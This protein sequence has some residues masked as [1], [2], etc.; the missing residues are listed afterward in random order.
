M[1]TARRT[2]RSW[3]LPPV[4]AAL[5]GLYRLGYKEPAWRLSP[6]R[7]ASVLRLQA[8]RGR[9]RGQR[10]FVI[11]NGPSLK[12]TDLARL[13]GER[14]FGLNRIYLKFE[15]LGFATTY[16]VCVNKLVISQ[17]AAELEALPC[18]KFIGWSARRHIRF[19]DDMVLVRDL[20]EPGFHEDPSDG[21]WEGST[22]TY[23]ALQLA[24]FMGFD[25]VILIGVDHDFATKGEPGQ[26][27]VSQGDDPN[28]FD[29]RYFGKGFRWELPNLPTSEQAYRLA[30]SHFEANGRRI[31]DATVGGKLAVFEKIDYDRLF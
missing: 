25:P 14:T 27:V 28:H 16:L 23:V 17:C 22:V 21:V 1:A 13:R 12:R 24:Y 5:H 10:C 31:W 6:K 15:E 19:T 7:R 18:P 30:R 3:T 9:H 20:A 29:P 8:L 4:R 2:L 26:V 11:G